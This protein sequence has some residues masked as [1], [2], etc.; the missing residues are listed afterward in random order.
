MYL[1]TI[2]LFTLVELLIVVGLIA[3]AFLAAGTGVYV[4]LG[5]IEKAAK[6]KKDAKD[7]GQFTTLLRH[8]ALG[9]IQNVKCN[10]R[11]DRFNKMKTEYEKIKGQLK[12]ETQEY[13]DEEIAESEEILIKDCGKNP[14]PPSSNSGDTSENNSN[15]SSNDDE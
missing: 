15:N 12:K 5:N 9:E 2:P 11:W 13:Y 8:F 3:I 14:N 7:K 4:I 6:A 1:Q 10:V